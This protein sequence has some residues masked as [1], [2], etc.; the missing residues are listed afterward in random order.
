MAD[1]GRN[2]GAS[3][4]TRGYHLIKERL[5]QVDLKHGRDIE[6][7]VAIG[8]GSKKRQIYYWFNLRSVMQA[9]EVEG[10]NGGHWGIRKGREHRNVPNLVK[11]SYTT[12]ALLVYFKD[13]QEK[14]VRRQVIAGKHSNRWGNTVQE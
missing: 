3:L 7:S 8:E 6:Q 1:L 10:S 12:G 14:L 5:K 9:Y 11:S 4:E 13:T 2:L